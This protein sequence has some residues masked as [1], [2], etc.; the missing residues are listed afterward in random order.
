MT[1]LSNESNLVGLWFSDQKHFGAKFDLENVTVQKTEPI[2]LTINWLKQYFAGKKPDPKTLPLAPR[3]TP[4]RNKVFKM[5]LNVPYGK[6]VTYN[7]IA[8][9][10]NQLDPDNHTSARAI[11]GAVG[12]NPISIIIPCHRVVGANGNLTGYAGGIDRKIA[13]LKLEGIDVNSLKR[14]AA[15]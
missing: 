14:P 11:G 12:H 10:I 3:S 7:Q 2:K 5:M 9:E 8:K 13:L 6:M 1:L 4:Y 15:K